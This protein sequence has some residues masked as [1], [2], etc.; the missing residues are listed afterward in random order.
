MQTIPSQPRSLFMVL[1]I[2]A[3]VGALTATTGLFHPA[4]A[5]HF[6]PGLLVAL[7]WCLAAPLALSLIDRPAPRPQSAA[8][9][10]L[11]PA[12]LAQTVALVPM[13]TAAALSEGLGADAPLLASFAAAQF[14]ILVG[15]RSLLGVVERGVPGAHAAAERFVVV[16]G[17]GALAAR[18]QSRIREHPEWGLRIACFLEDG[19][20]TVSPEID[21]ALI[22]KVVDIRP[23]LRDAVVDEVVVALPVAQLGCLPQVSVACREAGVALHL[24]ADLFDDGTPRAS[25]DRIGALSVVRFSQDRPT[26]ELVLKRLFDLAAAV[27]LLAAASPVIALAAAAIAATSRGPVFF[28]QRRCGLNGRNFEM[29]KLRTMVVDAESRLAELAHLNEMSGP[30]FKIRRDP[31]VTPVGRWLRRLSIDELPQL[32]NV[33]RGDMSLVGPRPPIP[34]EVAL[35]DTPHL[36]RLSM[37]P[38]LTGAWQV[39]GRNRVSNFADWVRLD[40]DYVDNWSFGLDLRILIRTIPAVLRATGE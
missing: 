19:Q 6:A 25:V 39:S 27:V 37:R 26:Q 7:V 12:A 2:V 21:H 8:A 32:W 1:E 16:V 9:G 38:G 40:L 17:V 30:V 31:R 36:R 28:R 4:G 15:S 14:A 18:L 20:E 35:Y 11:L 33:V 10:I 29:L 23:V 24:L 5:A 34:H 22:H 13:A 3:G